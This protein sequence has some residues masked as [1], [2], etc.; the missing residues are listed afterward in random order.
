MVSA[1]AESIRHL[2]YGCGFTAPPGWRHFDKSPTL[3]LERLPIVG[4]FV[5]KNDRRF[6]S[7]VE[8]GDIV[9]GLPV[10]NA[11]F[12][13]VYCSNVL[14]HLSLADSRIA[15]RNTFRLLAPGGIFRLVLP[16][17]EHLVRRYLDDPSPNAVHTLM[18]D[19]G[20]GREGVRRP[21]RL[22]DLAIDLF[23][24]T[25]H[26]WMYDFKAL[27][28]ALLDAGFQ[29]IRRASRGDCEDP[30][31]LAVEESDRWKNPLRVECHRA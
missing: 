14:E 20:L 1:S 19:S 21:V 22:A 24:N 26:L 12:D 25:R 6:P 9:T 11:H 29:G 2:Q 13:G 4:S 15:L 23:G 27:E 10:P 17:L 3:K 8:W 30:Q 7:N 31:F 5:R 16:D 28:A 18:R